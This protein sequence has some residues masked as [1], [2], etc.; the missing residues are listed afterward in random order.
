MSRGSNTRNNFSRVSFNYYERSGTVNRSSIYERES[1]TWLRPCSVSS[2]RINTSGVADLGE[3]GPEVQFQRRW[4]GKSRN[5]ISLIK[6]Y[7]EGLLQSTTMENCLSPQF[8][9]AGNEHKQV[10]LNCVHT[11]YSHTDPQIATVVPDVGS[12]DGFKVIE[13]LEITWSIECKTKESAK[14]L[15]EL[16]MRLG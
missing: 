3:I 14:A 12:T 16:H 2:V 1:Y 15:L 11:Y 9:K 5:L 7:E 4:L 10:V 8:V 13:T 6:E